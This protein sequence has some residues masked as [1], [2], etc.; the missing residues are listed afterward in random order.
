MKK[1]SKNTIV[2][3]LSIY[4]IT[5]LISSCGSESKKN[6]KEANSNIKEGGEVLKQAAINSGI[7]LKETTT[8]DWMKFKKESDSIFDEQEKMVKE[9]KIK[10]ASANKKEKSELIDYLNSIEKKIAMQKEKLVQKNDD[11]KSDV[12]KFDESVVAKNEAFKKEFNH[13]SNE[14]GNSI[15]DLF[16]DNVK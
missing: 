8:A 10:I 1:I 12:N 13:D 4:I 11:F 7:E 2:K 9:L 14:L 3:T 16:K 5:L 15:K 6:V